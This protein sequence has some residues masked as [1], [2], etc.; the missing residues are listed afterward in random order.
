MIS[1]W[2][3]HTEVRPLD[4]ATWQYWHIVHR[5]QVF[6]RSSFKAGIEDNRD[7]TWENEEQIMDI[8][9][10]IFMKVSNWQLRQFVSLDRLFIA[11]D[12]LVNIGEMNTSLPLFAIK[13]I[14]HHLTVEKVQDC[15]NGNKSRYNRIKYLENNFYGVDVTSSKLWLATFW[16]QQGDYSKA[17]H[18]INDVL[19]AIPP[20]ALYFSAYSIQTNIDSRRRYNE[21]YCNYSSDLITKA[22][23]AWLFDLRMTQKDYDFVSRAIQIELYYC[24][25]EIGIF[26]PPM[27]YAYYLMFLC[28]NGME[29]YDNRDYA[30]SQLIDTVSDNER[31][32][33]FKSSAYNITGHCLLITG[34]LDMA[35][36]FF[37]QSTQFSRCLSSVFDKYNTAYIYLSHM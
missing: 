15:R 2:K 27:A 5:Y 11:L 10:N 3:Y 17:L 23:E 7:R 16:L 36:S 28:Y 20:Y 1:V 8:M 12:A 22:R 25:P 14:C 21:M 13:Q 33:G 6:G 30:L 9:Y 19:S 29:Q 34:Q 32:L 31:S 18:N 37:V 26:M 24:D 4:K 35:R